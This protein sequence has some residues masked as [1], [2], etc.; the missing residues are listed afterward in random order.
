MVSLTDQQDPVKLQ[1]QAE[2]QLTLVPRKGIALPKHRFVFDHILAF[3]LVCNCETA[4]VRC[5]DCMSA[6]L[7]SR[8]VIMTEVRSSQDYLELDLNP[9][10]N[11]PHRGYIIE[12]ILN[13]DL[14]TSC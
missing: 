9:G 10:A 14:C 3:P 7:L 5:A 1:P 6:S 4:I 11:K 12:V 13:P 8:K 2:G